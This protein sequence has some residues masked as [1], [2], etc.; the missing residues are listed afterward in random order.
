MCEKQLLYSSKTGSLPDRPRFAQIPS[1]VKPSAGS[2]THF[3]PR[4][5]MVDPLLP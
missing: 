1:N 2:S 5:P 3:M 4:L